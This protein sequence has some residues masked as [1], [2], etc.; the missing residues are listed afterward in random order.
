MNQK[1]LI[2]IIA[3]AI[4]IVG[5]IYYLSRNNYGGENN[6][7]PTTTQTPQGSSQISIKNF[8][9]N[10]AELSINKGATVIW[11]NKD[12]T[13]H[14]ISGNGFQSMDLTNSRSYSFTFNNSGTYDYICSIHPGMKGKVIVK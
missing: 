14:R 3:V 12:P 2:A 7:T 4:V 8:A 10:P 5:S 9:F 1:T 11:I 13:T 6:P